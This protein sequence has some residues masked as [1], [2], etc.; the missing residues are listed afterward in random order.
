VLLFFISKTLILWLCEQ[1][2][3]ALFILLSKPAV[4]SISD[5][6]DSVFARPRSL[7]RRLLVYFW[8][9]SLAVF[10]LLLLLLFP[11][12]PGFLQR[13]GV[14]V[15]QQAIHAI[16]LLRVVGWLADSI[17]NF[18]LSIGFFLFFGGLRSCRIGLCCDRRNLFA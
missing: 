6:L 7:R 12:F 9:N 2:A 14:L 5:F 17:K 10:L 15:R 8:L 1:P 4:A 16:A 3:A 11:P 18:V 13:I